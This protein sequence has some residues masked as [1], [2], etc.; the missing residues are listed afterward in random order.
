[1]S[2]FHERKSQIEQTQESK[3]DNKQPIGKQDADNQPEQDT[4]LSR[5]KGEKEEET[6]KEKK[7]A[8][9]SNFILFYYYKLNFVYTNVIININITITINIF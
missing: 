5:E 7:R 4:N 9:L 6:G 3:R 8:K 1:M 2:Y